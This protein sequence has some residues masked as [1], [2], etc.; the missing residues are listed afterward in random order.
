MKSLLQSKTFWVAVLQ[1]VAGI[2]AVFYSSYP[3]VGE[4]LV[5]K[6]ALDVILRVVTSTAIGTK[7]V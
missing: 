6:S 2:V 1:A 3:A 4:L 7:N 5:A